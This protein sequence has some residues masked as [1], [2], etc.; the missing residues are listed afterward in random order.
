MAAGPDGSMSSILG[1]RLFVGSK[2]AAEDLLLLSSHGINCVV[3]VG[4]ESEQ[5]TAFLSGSPDRRLLL[6]SEPLD[7]P[8]T[9]LCSIF[10]DTNAFLAEAICRPGSR[11]C[12]LVHCRYGQSRSVAVVLAFLLCCWNQL[13]PECTPVDFP[14]ALSS[15]GLD[16]AL[17]W[18]LHKRPKMCLNPGFIAQLRWLLSSPCRSREATK[19]AAGADKRGVA[20]PTISVMPGAIVGSVDCAEVRLARYTVGLGPAPLVVRYGG[21][22]DEDEA[23]DEAVAP[24]AESPSRAPTTTPTLPHL[25]C[26]ACG[27]SLALATGVDVIFCMRASEVLAERQ[28]LDRCLAVDG[29]W[30]GYGGVGAMCGEKSKSRG[31]GKGDDKG[32]GKGEKWELSLGQG[33][34]KGHGQDKAQGK[35]QGKSQ[36]KGQGQGQGQGQGKGQG[37][38]SRQCVGGGGESA[39]EGAVP[40]EASGTSAGAGGAGTGTGAGT[41]AGGAGTGAGAGAGTGGAGTGARTGTGTGPCVSG[42][43]DGAGT[44]AGGSFKPDSDLDHLLIAPVDWVLAAYPPSLHPQYQSHPQPQS[45]QSTSQHQ[46]HPSNHSQQPQPPPSST[47]LKSLLCPNPQ[48]GAAVG[49]LVPFGLNVCGGLAKMH[50]ISLRRDS[51]VRTEC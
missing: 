20:A 40:P 14:L 17:A 16:G 36:D 44:D 24:T 39:A 3:S 37:K 13:P 43:A 28:L 49:L 9:L 6:F 51:V 33:Q 50:A 29:F 4:C 48:C 27:R 47:S 32:K 5:T 7:L 8:D 38:R 26:R 11:D 31:K 22:E 42:G 35:A 1:G 41:G 45:S 12:V 30:L 18:M 2:E 10:P 34:G 19:P 25:Q 23:V 46:S 15:Q 21:S